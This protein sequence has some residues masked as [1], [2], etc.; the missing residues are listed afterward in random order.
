MITMK[1][2]ALSSFIACTKRQ[3]SLRFRHVHSCCFQGWAKRNPRLFVQRGGFAYFSYTGPL[4]RVGCPA[5]FAAFAA[6][7]IP[8]GQS[9]ADHAGAQALELAG[10]VFRCQSGVHPAQA[11]R[12]DRAENAGKAP[13]PD[14]N[15]RTAMGNVPTDRRAARQRHICPVMRQA[16]RCHRHHRTQ[17]TANSH[18]KNRPFSAQHNGPTADALLMMAHA[19]SLFWRHKKSRGPDWT[20][21]FEDFD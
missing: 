9:A 13:C 2:H 17:R 10:R 5:D 12:A 14:K 18:H 6:G 21:D 8:A 19:S 4:F 16:R 3:R 1:R 11:L 20:H 15:R 7:A